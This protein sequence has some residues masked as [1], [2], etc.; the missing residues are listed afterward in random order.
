MEKFKFVRTSKFLADFSEGKTEFLRKF[1]P[2]ASL[3]GVSHSDWA[4]EV[5][6]VT[7][8]IRHGY[9]AIGNVHLISEE[10]WV[11]IRKIFRTPP[12]L[13]VDFR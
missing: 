12:P 5:L 2:C 9:E 11:E 13:A 7:D 10:E 1:E 6:R 4:H 8:S 3:L